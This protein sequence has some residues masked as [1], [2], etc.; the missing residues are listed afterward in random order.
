VK[1]SLGDLIKPKEGHTLSGFGIVV[2][3]ENQSGFMTEENDQVKYLILCS[4]SQLTKEAR[5]YLKGQNELKVLRFKH[6]DVCYVR[7]ATFK[8]TLFSFEQLIT[9][10]VAQV[11]Q[12]AL[13]LQERE[14]RE[15]R[16]PG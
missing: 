10:P 3:V 6:E 13:V 8:D 4:N 7:E 14:D 16:R 2:G 9:H 5:L 12:T 11:R 1:I 15:E